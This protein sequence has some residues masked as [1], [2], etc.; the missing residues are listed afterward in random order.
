MHGVVIH[1][2]EIYFTIHT[3][4][5]TSLATA[6][7]FILQLYSIL[8]ILYYFAMNIHSLPGSLRIFGVKLC[9]L[10]TMDEFDASFQRTLVA[11]DNR[12]DVLHRLT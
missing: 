5:R 7:Q 4:F 11:T 2:N 10:A 6:I 9:V 8:C 12:L 3:I 1:L